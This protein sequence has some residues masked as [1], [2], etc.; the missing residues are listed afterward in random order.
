MTRTLI[1]LALTVATA[2]PAAAME[3]FTFPSIDGGE[4]DSADWAGHPVLVVNTASRCGFT[5][6]YDGLQALYDEYKDEGLIVLAVPSDDFRQE[7][8]SA[9]EVKE[10]CDVNFGLTMPMT[11]IT[12][13]RGDAAH[14]FY[15]WVA[16]TSGFEP[17]WNFNKV[18]IAPDGSV[19]ATFGSTARPD[20]GVI[21]EPIQAMLAGS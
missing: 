2:L 1:A 15:K 16:A 17:S 3:R 19:A 10:F 21:V 6:Q 11:D 12:H 7:L 18:L 8:S 14:P 5:P 20:S 9:E 4:I 13:V